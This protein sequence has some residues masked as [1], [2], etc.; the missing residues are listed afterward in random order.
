MGELV[1]KCFKIIAKWIYEVKR[2]FGLQLH[3]CANIRCVVAAN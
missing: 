1:A 3:V 2:A